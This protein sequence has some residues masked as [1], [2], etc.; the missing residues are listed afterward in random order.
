M[1]TVWHNWFEKQFKW[2]VAI[3]IMFTAGYTMI[4]LQ[5]KFEAGGCLP[6]FGHDP[7]AQGFF[8]VFLSLVLTTFSTIGMAFNGS[9][10]RY[11]REGIIAA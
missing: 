6:C 9:K 1:A 7:E 2:I 8:L 11:S 4:I 5:D 3:Y 10:L